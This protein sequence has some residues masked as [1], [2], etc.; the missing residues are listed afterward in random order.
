MTGDGEAGRGRGTMSSHLQL[1]SSALWQGPALALAA[2]A[3]LLTIALG[4]GGT[5]FTRALSAS[6][7]LA[8]ALAAFWTIQ[9][10]QGQMRQMEKDLDQQDR[11]FEELGLGPR[12]STVWKYVMVVFA[13]A[14]LAVVV[15]SLSGRPSGWLPTT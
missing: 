14:N 5:R 11:Q 10:K 12:A 15:M 3:F 2:Q 7:A 8:T 13:A 6:L 1:E 9:R 4:E